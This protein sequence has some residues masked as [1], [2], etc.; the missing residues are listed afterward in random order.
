MRR[1]ETILNL[2]VMMTTVAIHRQQPP[3]AEPARAQA[4][5]ETK[6]Q[7]LTKSKGDEPARENKKAKTSAD[8]QSVITNHRL[9]IDGWDQ[10]YTA[11]TGLMPLKD[12]KGE[13]ET[14]TFFVAYNLESTGS[15]SGRPLLCSVDVCSWS[16]AAQAE[17]RRPALIDRV[18]G[19]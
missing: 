4:K 9:F 13:V 1:S 10:A 6:T 11:T 12:A 16:I 7:T 8:E 18:R 15:M 14:L 5:G 3:L 2:I 19:K 17:T